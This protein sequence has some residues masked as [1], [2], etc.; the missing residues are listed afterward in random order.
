MAHPPERSDAM[1]VVL[2]ARVAELATGAPVLAIDARST[3]CALVLAHPRAAPREAWRLGPLA[4][5]LDD[6][7]PIDA[8]ARDID[9]AFATPWSASPRVRAD[10]GLAVTDLL[11]RAA[12]A[13]PV[14]VAPDLPPDPSGVVVV[15]DP[16]RA[17][18]AVELRD[19]RLGFAPLTGRSPAI[20]AH[21]RP[22]DARATTLADV[23]AGAVPPASELTPIDLGPAE[24]TP[25]DEGVY[26][27][28]LSADAAIAHRLAAD[29]AIRLWAPEPD[30]SS[31]LGAELDVV[32]RC[33]G[34]R[35]DAVS[36]ALV[37]LAI[38]LAAVRVD[39]SLT[40]DPDHPEAA[41]LDPRR[42]PSREDLV[43]VVGDPFAPRFASA[44][45]DGD[46]AHATGRGVDHLRVVDALGRVRALGPDGALPTGLTGPVRL[47]A[48]RGGA[49]TMSDEL[50]LAA[51]APADVAPALVA[52]PATLALGEPAVFEVANARPDVS[53]TAGGLVL[54][55]DLATADRIVVDTRPLPGPGGYDLVFTSPAGSFES[56]LELTRAT[57]VWTRDIAFHATDPNTRLFQL[58]TALDLASGKALADGEFWRTDTGILGQDDWYCPLDIRPATAVIT[59]PCNHFSGVCDDL[60]V[61]G[62]TRNSAEWLT[63]TPPPGR[64]TTGAGHCPPVDGPAS[65]EGVAR[66][67]LLDRVTTGDAV[68]IQGQE[69]SGP[70]VEL[71]LPAA[72]GG[73][74]HIVP[75]AAS[76]GA[77][78]ARS[79]VTLD[80]DIEDAV[81]DDLDLVLSP[82]A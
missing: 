2:T 9:Q 67:D 63:V 68:F 77:P 49:S 70:N 42:G 58:P 79:D 41:L 82:T 71:T 16:A 72:R 4:A 11:R 30:P 61:W 1:L 60:W 50:A 37:A 15:R 33:Q 54:P 78:P 48:E 47:R 64:K 8:L 76:A 31:C 17:L 27:V 34:R 66:A 43:L 57:P 28:T 52:A 46:V 38:D 3:A 69:L 53:V 40:A 80:L 19:G 62:D 36:A 7:A 21:H 35:T 55:I 59:T 56:H 74:M 65:W 18:A 29:Q 6:A 75:P 32:A 5:L 23:L 73:G 39:G 20:D 13:W 45:I 51:V 81:G 22:L 10:Y 24:S 26:A 14:A 25:L 12:P 44:S